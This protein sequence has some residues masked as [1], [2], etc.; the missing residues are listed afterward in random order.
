VNVDKNEAYQEFKGSV[1]ADLN[2]AILKNIEDLRTKKEDI[3]AKT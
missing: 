1:G 3:K 2:N